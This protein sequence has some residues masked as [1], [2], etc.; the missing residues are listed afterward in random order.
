MKARIF[1]TTRGDGK[2]GVCGWWVAAS[3]GDWCAVGDWRRVATRGWISVEKCVSGDLFFFWR[4]FSL[5]FLLFCWWRSAGR[6]EGMFGAG[7]Q[8][9]ALAGWGWVR[10]LVEGGGCE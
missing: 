7:E 5:V 1:V 2:F 10:L 4:R 9:G 8:V 3:F 6:L